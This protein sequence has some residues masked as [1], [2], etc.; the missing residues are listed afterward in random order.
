[1]VVRIPGPFS[2]KYIVDFAVRNDSVGPDWT[3]ESS[4]TEDLMRY[5]VLT[6]EAM[7]FVV[8]HA[9]E[10]AATDGLPGDHHFFIAFQTQ[11]PDVQMSADLRERH[12]DEMTVVLQ[13]RFW[14]LEVHNDAFEVDLT[15]NNVPQ[16]LFIPFEAIKTFY[17][18][19][20][21]FGVQFN[22]E[23]AEALEAAQKPSDLAVADQDDMAQPSDTPESGQ[24]GS[25]DVESDEGGQVVQ[26][27]AF[28]K[29]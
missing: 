19:S 11:H 8:R 4:L 28:R 24:N 14:N 29:K 10:R 5:D 6:Q 22:I 3:W 13:H 27:D 12:P 23:P 25:G 7:R 16:H 20:V 1:M 17:D 9:L 26:L 18:P 21:E 2:P 15:F